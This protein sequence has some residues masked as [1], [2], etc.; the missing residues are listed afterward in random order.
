MNLALEHLNQEDA[1][2]G[3]VESLLAEAARLLEQG[4]GL[5]LSSTFSRY[6]PAW[7][8]VIPAI[9]AEVVA[10]ILARCKF[11]GLFLS[12][13]DIA[14][15]VCRRLQVSAIQVRGEVEPGVPAGELVGGQNQGMR[16]VTKAGGVGTEEAMIKSI[17]Y[18]ERGYL[19]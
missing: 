4:K 3:E 10:G 5:A 7:K 13:G 18:L 14:V 11:A 6:A 12:G 8:H 15:E 1:L 9:M 16:V 19:P 17:A 2:S